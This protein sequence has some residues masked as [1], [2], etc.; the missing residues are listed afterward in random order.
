[1]GKQAK[2]PV[3]PVLLKGYPTQEILNFAERMKNRMI[4]I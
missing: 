4:S 3:N 2:V 1:M